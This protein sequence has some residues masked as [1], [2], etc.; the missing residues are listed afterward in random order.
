MS[1]SGTHKGSRK[2]FEWNENETNTAHMGC[3]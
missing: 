1:H 3:S 2:Y